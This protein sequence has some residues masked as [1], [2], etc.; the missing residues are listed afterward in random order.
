MT[1]ATK[2]VSR[3]KKLLSKQ[4]LT[5]GLMGGVRWRLRAWG[6]EEKPGAFPRTVFFFVPT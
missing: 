2:D 4:F 3:R 1:A 6:E 5:K